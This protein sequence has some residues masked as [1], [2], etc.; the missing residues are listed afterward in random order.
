[1]PP[2]P[3]RRS[4]RLFAGLAITGAV[5]LL[6]AVLS[7]AYSAPSTSSTPATPA[8][9]PAESSASTRAAGDRWIDGGD[10]LPCVDDE[11]CLWISGC[12]LDANNNP[13]YPNRN[14]THVG[15]GPHSY[16]DQQTPTP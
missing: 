12:I 4:S 2:I 15:G 10:D 6:P 13:V 9:P 16:A 8:E 7:P 1:M 11:T 5:A 14:G 3:R